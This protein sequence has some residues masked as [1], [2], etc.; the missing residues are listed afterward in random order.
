MS[1]FFDQDEWTKCFV[2]I[3]NELFS[4]GWVPKKKDFSEKIGL[5][6]QTTLNAITSSQRDF[7]LHL[8]QMAMKVLQE[9]YYVNPK[10][11]LNRMNPMFTEELSDHPL[12]ITGPQKGMTYAEIIK[13]QQLKA[14]NELLR[15]SLSDK[16]QIIA[17]QAALIEALKAKNPTTKWAI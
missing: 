6:H 15:S 8:R 13:C 3:F 17:A 2:L 12:P 16:D 1:K 9:E 7:P 10:Y 11:F 5:K 4:K 14:E